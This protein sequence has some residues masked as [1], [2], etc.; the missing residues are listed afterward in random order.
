[1]KKHAFIFAIFS[2]A[3]A[4]TIY[5]AV[6]P[7]SLRIER[8]NNEGTAL[9]KPAIVPVTAQGILTTDASG[10]PTVIAQ[11]T[12]A[13]AAVLEQRTGT[14]LK[15]WCGTQAQYDAIATKDAATLYNIFED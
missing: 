10:A 3:I 12:F 8:Y 9:A 1:M 5:A 4:A 14:A 6:A 2:A 7:G 15:I 13:A 11:S